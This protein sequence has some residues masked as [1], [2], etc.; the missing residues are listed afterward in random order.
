[1]MNNLLNCLMMNN[2]F[3]WKYQEKCLSY[4]E[5]KKKIKMCKGKF[6]NMI[7]LITMRWIGYEWVFS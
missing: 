7:G 1:M 6:M 5:E 2:L 3:I 4:S